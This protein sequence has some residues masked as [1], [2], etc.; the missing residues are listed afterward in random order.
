MI[1]RI[2]STYKFEVLLTY[3]HGETF[4]LIDTY[5]NI[6]K[7]LRNRQANIFGTQYNYARIC[8]YP[9][10]NND[11]IIDMYFWFQNEKH[12]DG[13]VAVGGLDKETRTKVLIGIIPSGNTKEFN[14]QLREWERESGWQQF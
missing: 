6:H 11:L 5:E 14:K 10:Q 8:S 3:E 12:K 13:H 1:N 4:L 9:V 7:L 2:F